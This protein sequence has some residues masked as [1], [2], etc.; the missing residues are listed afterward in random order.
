MIEWLSTSAGIYTLF[1]L[2]TAIER[3][4]E[5]RVSNRN[6]AWSFDQGGVERGKGHYPFMVVLHTGFLFAC[7]GEV[8]LLDRSFLPSLGWPMLGLA[9]GCQALRWWCITSLG[10]RWN[11]RVILVPGLKRLTNGPY[12]FFSHPNYVA[13]VLE[14]FALPLLHTAVWTCVGFTILNAGLLWVRI[15]C[16][17]QALQELLENANAQ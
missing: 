8:L 13:V 1:I 15:R 6:A 4:Y 16:E 12:R 2:A 5:V 3:L 7:I 14:G 11:T 10:H 9:I 17:E